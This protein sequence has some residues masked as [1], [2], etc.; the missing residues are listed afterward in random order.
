VLLA[1][2]ESRDFASLLVCDRDVL[3]GRRCTDSFVFGLRLRMPSSDTRE[4]VPP[5]GAS[6]IV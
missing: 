3:D 1:F 6:T 4:E 5:S 2:R